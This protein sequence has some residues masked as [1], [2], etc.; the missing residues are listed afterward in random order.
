M[1]L[2]K[3]WNHKAL[4]L[5][6]AA[7]LF[8]ALPQAAPQQG[9]GDPRQ[10]VELPPPMRAHMM[11]N[12]RD[13]LQAIEEITRLLSKRHYEAAG[14]VA[15]QR[16]GMSAM[17]AHGAGHMGKFMPEGMRSIGQAMHRSASRFAVAAQDAAVDDDLAG[18]FAGLSLVMQ[19]CV[20]CHEGFRVH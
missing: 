14:D 8:A 19:Q 2:P 4:A 9:N 5:G 7:L 15:E 12:M 10:K 1:S 3:P 13:H 6:L 17:G 18:A 11:A 16:L 20:A